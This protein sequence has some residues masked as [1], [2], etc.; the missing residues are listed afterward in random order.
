MTRRGS[1]CL[2]N[3]FGQAMIESL[4]QSARGVT[5]VAGKATFIEGAL[6]GEV[7]RF[8]YR[9]QH[10]RYDEGTVEEIL[11]ASAQRVNA[12]CVHFNICG[13]CAMQ[14]LA[15]EAQILAKQQVILDNLKHIGAVVPEQLAPPLTGPLWGY[16]RR[17]RLGVKYVLK[18][19]R[20]LI[21]FRERRSA[22]LA[23]LTRCEVLHPFVGEN[24]MALRELVSGLAARDHIAQ[25]EVAV[26]DAMP[27]LIFRHLTALTEADRAQLRDFGRA[28][29]CQ[30][31]LQ[32][33]GPT[34]VMPLWPDSPAPL[35]Y[36]LPEFAIENEFLP[37]DFVQI[38]GELN[39][40]MVAQAVQWLNP[41]PQE[42]V[43]DLFCGLGNF[44]LALARFA[45]RVVGVE[46]EASLIERARRNARRNG[47]THAAFHVADLTQPFSGQPWY[48]AGFDKILIDPPRSGALEA[49]RQLPIVPRLVYVSCNPATLARDAAMLV[50]EQG[51]RLQRVGAL[52]M[53]PHTTHVEAMALFTHAV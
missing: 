40:A 22:Y 3:V 41:Q 4:D 36:T 29:A 23:E 27:A 50:H 46:A 35:T 32:S 5:H 12:R 28:Q 44:T 31:W 38:N 16:R 13:G 10:A 48:G 1:K 15:P 34:T 17:A 14:H 18:K 25:I 47:I 30:I 19:E 53:F 45:A 24:I 11:Q 8:Q 37:T 2:P 7:V 52:D 26:G 6:P 51:Y 33:G 42:G 9:A 49:L 20:L 21:G 39:R 43:L